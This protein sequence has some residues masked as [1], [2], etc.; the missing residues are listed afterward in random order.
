[1]DEQRRW[2]RER[3]E[4]AYLGLLEARNRV[5]R[6]METE[7]E[8]LADGRQPN[9]AELDNARHSA[10]RDVSHTVPVV[11]L[12]GS[13]QAAAAARKW[14]D[15]LWVWGEQPAVTLER[16]KTIQ[17]QWSGA[18]GDELREH[19]DPFIRLIRAELGVQTD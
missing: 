10:V 11:E 19:Y 14:A 15:D 6:L 18:F 7:F 13:E 3:R 12:F 9:L 4:T 17:K 2:N 16:F 5:V 8:Q 1:M